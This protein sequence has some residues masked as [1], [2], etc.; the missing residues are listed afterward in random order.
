MISFATSF[1]YTRL[2]GL[3]VSGFF[4]FVRVWGVCE[5]FVQSWVWGCSGRE[6][7]KGEVVAPTLKVV[8]RALKF[9]VTVTAPDEK[10]LEGT[11]SKAASCVLRPGARDLKS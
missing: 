6:F 11:V 5:T 4:C 9:L 8:P 3:Q 7:L 10:T 1:P 2:T